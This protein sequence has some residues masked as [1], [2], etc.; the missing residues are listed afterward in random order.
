[1]YVGKTT[2]SMNKAILKYVVQSCKILKKDEM[3]F[4]SSS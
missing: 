4:F 2:K 1:M 3:S